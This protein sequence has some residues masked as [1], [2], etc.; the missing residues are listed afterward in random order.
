MIKTNNDLIRQLVDS[1]YLKTPQI[2]RA[3]K[4]IDRINFV[5]KDLE[6][7][8]YQ[9][10]PLP[11]GSGQT[12]SQ[13][14]T[15]AFMLELSEIKKNDRVFEVGFGS[16]WQTALMAEIVGDKG[17]IFAVERIKEIWELGKFNI[18]KYGFLDKGIVKIYCQDGSKGLEEGAPFDKIISAASIKFK[19]KNFLEAIP[20]VWKSQLKIGGIIVTPIEH[21]IFKFRKVADNKFEIEEYPGFVF[22]PLVKNEDY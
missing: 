15:V 2:I 14:L 18:N 21:S 19:G 22:V 6:A 1:G 11:I 9:N 16:G 7:D 17:R 8:A 5:P 13:P 20:S 4:K 10:I 3:F 12:I